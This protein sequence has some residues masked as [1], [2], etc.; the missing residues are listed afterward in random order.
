MFLY[1]KI[2]FNLIKRI[3]IKFYKKIKLKI[4]YIY[5]YK[6]KLF[7]KLKKKSFKFALLLFDIIIKA[8]K[9]AKNF[10]IV[11]NLLI[12]KINNV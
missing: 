7:K 9:K 8:I 1:N 12:N 11:F 6:K 4:I 3:K 10:N 5:N 2:T